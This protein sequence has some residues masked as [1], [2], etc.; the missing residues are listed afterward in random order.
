[1]TKK[2]HSRQ[3]RDALRAIPDEILL[4]APSSGWCARGPNGEVVP[5]VGWALT[6]H[7]NVVPLL[8]PTRQEALGWD[9]W[10]PQERGGEE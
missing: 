2:S 3:T 9:L 1:V 7:G 10:H 6:M 4:I 8:P 5:L